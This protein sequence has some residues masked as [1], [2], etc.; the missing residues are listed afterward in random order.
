MVFVILI[1]FLKIIKTPLAN[2]IYNLGSGKKTSINLI[3]KIFGG[4]KK[5]IPIRP[6]EPKDSLANI[7]KIKKEIKWKPKISIK[8][9]IRKLLRS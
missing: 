3:A 6:G 1:S 4:K 5:F 7:S 2:K 9:G 8:E